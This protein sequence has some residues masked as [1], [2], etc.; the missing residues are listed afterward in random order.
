MPGLA[1]EDSCP[2]VGS[3]QTLS[4]FHVA[5]T[6]P[7][8]PGRA[9]V[10]PNC[11]CG[12]QHEAE[13]SHLRPCG[14]RSKVLFGLNMWLAHCCSEQP[15]FK[16]RRCRK[17]TESEAPADPFPPQAEEVAATVTEKLMMHCFGQ[18]G[19]GRGGWGQRHEPHPRSC[20]NTSG[21]CNRCSNTQRCR[22]SSCLRTQDP[23]SAGAE[24]AGAGWQGQWLVIGSGS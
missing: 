22:R 1:A 5:A 17:H 13:W 20:I 11:G 14:C 9:G 8:S 6:F 2:F 4:E 16:K 23:Q 15:A 21:R 3:L 19:C 24:Q 12:R 10:D 7:S 18:W